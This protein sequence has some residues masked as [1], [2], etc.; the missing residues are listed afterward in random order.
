MELACVLL[1]GLGHN[2]IILSE[3]CLAKYFHHTFYDDSENSHDNSVAKRKYF[4]C[5]I[6]GTLIAS[7]T[8]DADA[9]V[10]VSEATLSVP[11]GNWSLT[12]ND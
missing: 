2:V 5:A 3:S 11:Q 1:N 10:V 12:L 4:G 9:P 8:P 7:T 6:S